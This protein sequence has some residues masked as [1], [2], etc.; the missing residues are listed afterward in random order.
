MHEQ[1]IQ[2]P[3]YW[4]PRPD[5]VTSQVAVQ[6][7]ALMCSP[8]SLTPHSATQQRQHSPAEQT[9]V[10]L[11]SRADKHPADW[12]RLRNRLRHMKPPT[13]MQH[14]PERQVWLLSRHAALVRFECLGAAPLCSGATPVLQPLSYAGAVVRGNDAPQMVPCLPQAVKA[15]WRVHGW[16]SI[17]WNAQSHCLLPAQLMSQ[18]LA[19]CMLAR[20][21]A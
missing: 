8:H 21:H 11:A 15:G 5:E 17:A 13:S 20:M 9:P 7:S 4:P 12:R 1:C 19:V 18:R 14:D 10:V 2:Q 3:A 6:P 16:K